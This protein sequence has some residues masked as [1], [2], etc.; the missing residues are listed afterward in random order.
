[1]G[2]GFKMTGLGNQTKRNGN[3][4][5]YIGRYDIRQ[6]GLDVL[7]L[8]IGHIKEQMLERGLTIDLYG[9]S[10]KVR[11]LLQQQAEVNQLTGVLTIH[12]PVF[13]KMKQEALLR[14]D[15]FVATSRFEG[16]PMA[17]LEAMNYAVPAIL[18]PGTN[19]AAEIEETESG[20]SSQLDY[21]D[22]GGAIL[23][24]FED[25]E[26]LVRRGKNARKLVEEQYSWEIIA[27]KTVSEY[28]RLL[29]D[30]Q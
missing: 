7:M 4:M 29:E 21:R 14:A 5:I 30:R 1:M 2:N 6:K 20:W 9:S 18:T 10:D 28:R 12:G 17:I 27:R 22:V 11:N 23:R 16:H 25:P 8:A 13:G 3:R 26:E 24:A 15:L 19:M